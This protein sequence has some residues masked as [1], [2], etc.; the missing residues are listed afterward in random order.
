VIGEVARELEGQGDPR[1]YVLE[2]NARLLCALARYD[3]AERC[4]LQGRAIAQRGGHRVGQ[5]RMDLML[6][7]NA[8]R[9]RQWTVASGLLAGLQGDGEAMGCPATDRRADLERWLRDLSFG[10][11]SPRR[12]ATLRMEVALVTAEL[13]ATRGKYLSALLLVSAVD[14]ELDSATVEIDLDQVA[15]LKVE[16][17]LAAGLLD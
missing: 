7:H 16:W 15:L 14:S 6:A 13:W 3:E 8:V 9:A 11:P 4:L 2:W 5:F 12:L 17:L 1:Q 10:A